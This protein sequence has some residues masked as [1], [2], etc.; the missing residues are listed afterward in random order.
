MRVKDI[1]VS[2]AHIR[3][4]G[5]YGAIVKRFSWSSLTARA[6]QVAKASMVCIAIAQLGMHAS[7]ADAA[8]VPVPANVNKLDCSTYNGGIK[9]GDVLVLT[10]RARGAISL[11][12]C[13]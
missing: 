1:R 8:T 7:A 2:S 6:W 3:S 11:S 13:R 10:G 4:A 12:N 9:P 5:G